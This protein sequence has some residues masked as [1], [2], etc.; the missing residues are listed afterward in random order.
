[1]EP[2]TKLPE[3][4]TRIWDN[5]IPGKLSGWI[6]LAGG[7][8]EEVFACKAIAHHPWVG[9]TVLFPGIGA[10]KVTN[11]LTHPRGNLLFD[12]AFPD[13][14]PKLYHAQ[15]HRYFGDELKALVEGTIPIRT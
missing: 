9:L 8:P 5:D 13:P 1:M 6:A 11:C 14:V 3:A 2:L 4:M 12:V 10:G 15:T 7:D